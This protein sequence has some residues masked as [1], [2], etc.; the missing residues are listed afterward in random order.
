MCLHIW[1]SIDRFQFR[2]VCLFTFV[3]NKLDTKIDVKWYNEINR[4]TK[5]QTA[6]KRD[7]RELEFISPTFLPQQ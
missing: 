4:Q 7:G 6:T 1:H 5:E 2:L 3:D